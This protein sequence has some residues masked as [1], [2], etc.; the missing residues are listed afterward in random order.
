MGTSGFAGVLV[1][2]I[3]FAL[4]LPVVVLVVSLLRFGL[5]GMVT[6]D[7]MS[8]VQLVVFGWPSGIPLT[9]AVLL[10]HRRVQ[11]LAYVCAVV[12]APFSVLAFIL[13]GLFGPFVLAYALVVSLPAWVA[14]GVVALLQS[15][16]S[17]AAGRAA[18]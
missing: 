17:S 7:A 10:L 1:R 16:Y 3:L 11:L 9:L 15:R 13:G 4:W 5:E 6:M 8:L 14:L 12:L 18:E 2:A